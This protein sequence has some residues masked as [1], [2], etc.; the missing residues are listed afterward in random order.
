MESSLAN[1][2]GLTINKTRLQYQWMNWKNSANNVS[3]TLLKNSVHNLFFTGTNIINF[4]GVWVKLHFSENLQ[5]SQFLYFW[6]TIFMCCMSGNSWSFKMWWRALS[7][8]KGGAGRPMSPNHHTLIRPIDPLHPST[9]SL[10]VFSQIYLRKQMIF[11]WDWCPGWV[12]S[13]LLKKL[14]WSPMIK[15]LF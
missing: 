8:T 2:G 13:L 11:L 5:F 4:S 10:S 15:S 1:H 7:E 6:T 9:K 3:E 14:K 12:K